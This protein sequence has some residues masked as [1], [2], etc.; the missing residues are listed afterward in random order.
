MEDTKEIKIFVSCP[1]DVESEK[2]IIIKVCKDLNNVFEQVKKNF[3]FFFYD[4]KN[5][6]G[7]YS[8]NTQEQ[9]DK[10][11]SNYNIYIGILGLRFG[12]PPGT[13]HP[14]TGEAFE[15]GTQ[16]EFELAILKKQ[17]ANSKIEVYIFF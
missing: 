3:R 16:A 6:V 1:S 7:E 5:L 15:S 12:T 17:N 2:E 11:F 9:I 13:T 8:T 10:T 4:W 14:F